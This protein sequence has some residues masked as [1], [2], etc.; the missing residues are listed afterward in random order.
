MVLH[1]MGQVD[2]SLQ[3]FLR[4][5]A[6]DEDFPCAKRQVE[7]VRKLLLVCLLGGKAILDLRW[8][9]FKLRSDCS[10]HCFKESRYIYVSHFFIG[11]IKL[12]HNDHYCTKPFVLF[13]V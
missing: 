3:V 2:E 5:L 7:K 13:Y 9:S 12:S 8:R 6:V 11:N 10:R 1:E 4:C